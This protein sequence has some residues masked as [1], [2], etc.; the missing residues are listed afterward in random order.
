MSGTP[1]VTD[2]RAYVSS[3]FALNI[4]GFDH[5]GFLKSVDGGGVK[6]EPINYQQGGTLD[7]WRSI[8]K[9]KYEDLSIQIG[10]G[11]S[12]HFYLWIEDFFARKMTRKNGSIVT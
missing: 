5:C 3:R 2:M 12:K 10:M 7:V 1:P 11:M 8:S 6:A 9:P 4:D